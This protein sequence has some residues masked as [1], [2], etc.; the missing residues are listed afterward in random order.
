MSK[1]KGRRLIGWL[2]VLFTLWSLLPLVN[3]IVNV[4]VVVPFAVGVAGMLFGFRSPSDKPKKRWVKRMLA[5]AMAMVCF[6]GVLAVVMSSIMITAALKKPTDEDATVVVL[7][8]GI[9]G[10]RPSRM[11]RHRL[12]AAV[13]YLEEHPDSQCVVTGGQGPDEDYTE[14]SVMEK[15]LLEKGVEAHRIFRE[16]LSTS[17]NEN[18]RFA[19]QIIR[20]QELNESI[21]IATQEFHQYRASVFARR[22]GLTEVR[23]LSRLSPPHLLLCYWVRECAAICRLWLLGQ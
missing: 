13:A 19:A 20:E 17:T 7:G 22:Y 1:R 5:V 2:S 15:Y 18:M 4:G 10:D 16:E 23:A 11:L 12:D 8:A 9:Y 3:G 21:V 6:F 14:A